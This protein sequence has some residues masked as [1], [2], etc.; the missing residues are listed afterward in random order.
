MYIQEAFAKKG[1]LRASI[2]VTLLIIKF[3]TSIL[4]QIVEICETL[5]FR[6]FLGHGDCF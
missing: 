4:A 6:P 5:I 2:T 3:S 1:D